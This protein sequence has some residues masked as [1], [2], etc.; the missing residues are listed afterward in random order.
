MVASANQFMSQLVFLFTGPDMGWPAVDLCPV[1]FCTGPS[2]AT[3]QNLPAMS[4]P[5]SRHFIFLKRLC[6]TVH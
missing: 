3:A 6:I 4:F 2:H 5:P 1:V